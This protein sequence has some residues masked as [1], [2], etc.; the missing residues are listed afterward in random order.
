LRRT[1]LKPTLKEPP[2]FKKNSKPRL[3]IFLKRKNCT[4]TMV[5]TKRKD[6]LNFS[7]KLPIF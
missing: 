3:E 1:K 7:T 4:L 6:A 2:I 5:V